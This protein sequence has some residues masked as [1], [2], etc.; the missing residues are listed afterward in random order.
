MG[1]K[2]SPK[3]LF[4]S[5]PNTDGI[6]RFYISQ[7]SVATQLRCGVFS[8]HVIT[9]FPQNAPVRKFQESVNTWQTCG[10]KFVAYF[11]GP[12][13]KTNRWRP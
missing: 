5:S 3:L 6:Y 10:Q 11:L 7:G 13:C 2:L 9:N 12:P 4:I 1:K 8:N